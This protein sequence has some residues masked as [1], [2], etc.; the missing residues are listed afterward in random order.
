VI[1]E[2]FEAELDE[3]LVSAAL[4]SV[5]EVVVIGFVVLGTRAEATVED[6]AELIGEIEPIICIKSICLSL[7]LK[8]GH[9]YPFK[10]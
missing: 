3:L 6:A 2:E 10:P 9:L 5:V 7:S 4:E 8:S 1:V